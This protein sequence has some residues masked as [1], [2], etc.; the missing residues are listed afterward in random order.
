MSAEVTEIDNNINNQQII[1]DYIKK[2]LPLVEMSLFKKN[3]E[4]MYESAVLEEQRNKITD[5]MWKITGIIF[6]AVIL[7]SFALAGFISHLGDATISTVVLACVFLALGVVVYL[8]SDFNVNFLAKRALKKKK[9]ELEIEAAKIRKQIDNELDERNASDQLIGKAIEIAISNEY[10]DRIAAVLVNEIA[11]EFLLPDKDPIAKDQMKRLVLMILAGAFILE[12]L[13]LDVLINDEKT[14]TELLNVLTDIDS[15]L[16]IVS[17]NKFDMFFGVDFRKMQKSIKN[18]NDIIET[19]QKINSNKELAMNVEE[20]TSKMKKQFDTKPISKSNVK[21]PHKKLNIGKNRLLSA[22]SASDGDVIEIRTRAGTYYTTTKFV[23]GNLAAKDKK[24]KLLTDRE[25]EVKMEVL[26]STLR[27]LEEEKK[28][29]SK[30]DFESIKN[31]Y[32]MQLMGA[33]QVL[34]K[35]RGSFKRITCPTCGTKNSS[36]KQYCKKCKNQ[37]PYCIVCLSSIGVGTEVIIC[38]HCQ[39]FGHAEHFT[40]WLEKT[41][42]CPYCKEKISKKLEPDIV[43]KIV[44]IKKVK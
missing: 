42:I 4:S 6:V 36:I 35:R 18:V 29:L 12:S 31:D 37:L 34:T 5:K 32:L 28:S 22:I 13:N 21:I 43:E 40:Q 44:K 10:R 16:S 8:L 15:S 38:P 19:L 26:N 23:Q 30:K 1:S 2:A 39:S 33:E 7:A 41:D 11:I 3:K 20:L 14:L 17:Q 25:I 27:L 24:V 9:K